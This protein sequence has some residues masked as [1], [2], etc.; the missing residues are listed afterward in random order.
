MKPRFALSLSQDKIGLFHRTSGAWSL[1]GEA[2]LDAPDLAETLKMMRAT[3]SELEGGGVLSFVVIPDEMI[4]YTT[5]ETGPAPGAAE[6]RKALDGLTPY[7]VKDL[8]F[9]WEMDGTGARV[10]VVA[11]ET[12]AEAERFAAQHRFNPVAHVAA[13]A[14]ESFPRM[15]WFGATQAAATLLP[16]GAQIERLDGRLELGAPTVRPAPP[17]AAVPPAA[18]PAQ[19][20]PAPRPQSHATATPIAAPPASVDVSPAPDDTPAGGRA[21]TMALV[22]GAVALFAIALAALWSG[23]FAGDDA[24]LATAPDQ[25]DGAFTVAIPQID[26]PR[27]EDALPEGTQATAPLM[28]QPGLE[29]VPHLPSTPQPGGAI[30]LPEPAMPAHTLAALAPE[31]VPEIETAAAPMLL[32]PDPAG[33]RP[34]APLTL[35]APPLEPADDLYIAAIDPV[36]FS[37]DA[38]ALPPAAGLHADTP[39][40]PQRPAGP[41]QAFALDEH[42]RVTPRKGGALDPSGV[43]IH[44]GPPPRVPPQRPEPPAAAIT[45]SE[46]KHLAKFIPRSRPADLAQR[47][48]QAQTGGYGLD[49]LSQLRPRARPDYVAPAAPVAPPVAVAAAIK[50]LAPSPGLVTRQA[51]Q[52]NAINLR[53][54]SLIGVYGS[55]S[56]RRALVRLPDGQFVKVKP[57]DSIDGGRVA[58]IGEDQLRYIKNGANILLQLAGDG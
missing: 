16:D 12:L 38:V 51:T 55:E 45:R 36:I 34:D 32:P 22:L 13:P 31:A 27:L 28:A 8:V 18:T 7:N 3:A 43:M 54:I 14:P 52:E 37:E 4:L 2:M 30:A 25:A 47:L 10:A 20:A 17:V 40:A 42:G 6:I 9:D 5:L 24:P 48:E 1:V 56:D 23:V 21:R 44:A 41:G 29:P 15:P 50:P 26:A 19:P 46:N 49:A 57:G 35:S 58:A 11:Q 53:K 33:I 39:P